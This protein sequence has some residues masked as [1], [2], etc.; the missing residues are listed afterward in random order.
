MKLFV[1]TAL[2]ATAK[3]DNTAAIAA[4]AGKICSP[5]TFSDF[6][7]G[8]GTVDIKEFDTPTTTVEECYA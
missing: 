6:N 1:L 4:G 2:L 5:S 7:L 8:Y 3:A